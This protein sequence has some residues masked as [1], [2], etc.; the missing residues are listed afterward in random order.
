MKTKTLEKKHLSYDTFKQTK[1]GQISGLIRDRLWIRHTNALIAIF[2]EPG[3]G[4][5]LSAITLAR[6]V[7]DRFTLDNV[8]YTPEDFLDRLDKASRGTVVIFD[9]AG[10]G[11]PAREWQSLQ[12]KLLNY[13]LQTFRYQNICVI[14]TTPHISYIDRQARHLLNY[15]A[16]TKGY[17]AKYDCF[18][19]YWYYRDVNPFSDYPRFEPLSIMQNGKKVELGKIYIPFPHEYVDA[20]EEMARK[21]KTEIRRDAMKKIE[22]MKA[23]IRADVDMRQIRRLANQSKAFFKLYEYVKAEYNYSD[24]EIAKILNVSNATISNWVKQ[25]REEGVPEF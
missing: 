17:V 3:S 14:F 10:V 19:S 8:V 4:K 13:V 22:A 2:G 20:Y 25:Y 21:R 9:E 1:I 15:T 23:G 18:E 24:R 7:D 16:V 11:I 5:S 12:N 6:L